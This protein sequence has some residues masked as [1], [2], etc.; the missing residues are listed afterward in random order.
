MVRGHTQFILHLH[1][2]YLDHHAVN[3]VRKVIHACLKL[4]AIFYDCINP[5]KDFSFLSWGCEKPSST[6]HLKRAGMRLRYV[7]FA[8]CFFA[9]V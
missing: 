3:F 8:I 4:V 6:Q 9:L 7:R 1:I 5:F 2:V